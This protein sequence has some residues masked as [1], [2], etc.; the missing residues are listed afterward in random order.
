MDWYGYIMGFLGLVLV[1]TLD[2]KDRLSKPVTQLNS[3]T[4]RLGGLDLAN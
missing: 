3:A 4:M 2:S 1:P